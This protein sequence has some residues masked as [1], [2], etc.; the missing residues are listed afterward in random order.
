M[1]MN[2]PV[3]NLIL[4]LVVLVLGFA[5]VYALS[6]FVQSVRPV[7][8]PAYEDEDL[9]FQAGKLKNYSLGLNGLIADWYWMQSLQYMGA[10]I[11][12]TNE[13]SINLDNLTSLNPR[14]LYP[15]L[16]SATTFDPKFNTAYVYGAMVLPAV[17]PALAIRLLEK[18]IR[19]NPD[20]W[21]LYHYL[22]FIYWRL[23]NFE[24]AF[25]L[26]TQGSNLPNAPSFMKVMAAQMKTQGGNR[27]TARAMY[28]RM[29]NDA[30]DT[31]TRQ[32][33]EIRLMQL[34]SLDER[35]ALNTALQSFK[36][37]NNRCANNWAEIFPLLK[38][39][40]LPNGKD[41]RIDRDNN[42]VDPSDAPYILNK[43]CAAALDAKKSKIPL[44]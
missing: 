7:P 43:Q 24:K 34:D 22:G 35:D 26:Y 4:T 21:Q 42:L 2:K 6:N 8:P 32:M 41:F 3:N 11:E 29:M 5:A 19:E 33:A 1:A 9:A 38:A 44:Q 18:G 36:E 14:L 17:D 23:G 16:D 39:V 40:K 27:S 30:E 28:E 37:K 15:L 20:N 25:E 31:Q 12:S 10:K 13:T